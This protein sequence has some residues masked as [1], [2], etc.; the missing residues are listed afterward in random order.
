MEKHFAELTPGYEDVWILQ[1]VKIILPYL[2]QPKSN[3]FYQR[4]VISAFKIDPSIIKI[5]YNRNIKLRN[6]CKTFRF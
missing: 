6:S 2:K 1:W 4:L 5:M 3:V